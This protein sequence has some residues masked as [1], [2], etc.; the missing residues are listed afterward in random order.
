MTDLELA[1][2]ANARALAIQEAALSCAQILERL[3][4]AVTFIQRF[5]LALNLNVHFH[6]LALD[7]VYTYTLGRGGATRVGRLRGTRCSDASSAYQAIGL[8]RLLYSAW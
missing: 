8:P 7:G 2:Q 6:S 4:G 5:G 1:R 3:C